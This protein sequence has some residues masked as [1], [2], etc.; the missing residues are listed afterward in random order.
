MGNYNKASFYV[1]VCAIIGLTI[2]GNF[3]ETNVLEVHLIGAV[4]TFLALHAYCWMQIVISKKFS[5]VFYSTQ[6]I[7]KTR[8]ILCI[9]GLAN[10]ILLFAFS[11][12]AKL[13]FHGKNPL[14]WGKDDGGWVEHVISTA[15]EWSLSIVTM[16]VLLTF[17]PD[18]KNAYMEAP[19]VINKRVSSLITM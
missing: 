7:L 11:I 9:F 10:L 14:K 3:Q 13:K 15:N 1:V 4:M 8:L 5:D 17:L 19:K 16:F 12:V 18:F 2:V 6:T